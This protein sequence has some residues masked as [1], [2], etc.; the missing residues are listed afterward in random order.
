M[1]IDKQMKGIA[2]YSIGEVLGPYTASTFMLRDL[3]LISFCQNYG[4]DFAS[5]VQSFWLQCGK[6]YS[7]FRSPR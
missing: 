3:V 5:Y 4:Y 1:L 6:Y 7:L 2:L